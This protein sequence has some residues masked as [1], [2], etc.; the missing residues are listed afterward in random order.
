MIEARSLSRSFGSIEAVREVDVTV[1][2][3]EIAGLLG[4]NGAG[5]STV[6]RM[7]T[8]VLRPGGGRVRIGGSDLWADPPAAK[9]RIGYL[10]E[11]APVYGELNAAEYLEFLAGAR[12][13]S[14][15]ETAG[16]IERV[17]GEC[18]IGE[19]LYRPLMYLSKGYRQRTALAGA[20]V[21]APEILILDEPTTGLDPRQMHEIRELIRRIGEERTVLLSTHILQEA[22]SLCS[23]VMI[24]SKGSIVAQGVPG[25]SDSGGTERRYRIGVKN[26]EP[27]ELEGRFRN[28][29]G[30]IRTEEVRGIR[31]GHEAEVVAESGE[32]GADGSEIFSWACAEG[33]R[34][35]YFYPVKASLEQMFLQALREGGEE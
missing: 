32:E 28:M 29:P 17:S 35:L 30:F 23:R 5:K 27:A 7:L 1:H 14:G 13:L 11:S 24:L 26:S 3:G 31:G 10:P 21:H 25:E 18:G 19:A 20:L 16:A 12:G 9:R 4:P 15:N 33:L 6:L 22:E 34:L 8:G 2:A